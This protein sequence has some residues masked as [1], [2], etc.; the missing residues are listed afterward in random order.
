VGISPAGTTWEEQDAHSSHSDYFVRWFAIEMT[1]LEVWPN[2]GLI[3]SG[4][5]V[6]GVPL[7]VMRLD[8]NAPQEP[9]R[10]GQPEGGK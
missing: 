6:Q 5:E 1:T 9:D 8:P 3:S 7:R 4:L 2:L 10:M